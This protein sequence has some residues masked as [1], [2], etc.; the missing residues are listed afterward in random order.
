MHLGDVL[1]L[2]SP[3][4]SALYLQL[5][6]SLNILFGYWVLS[7]PAAGSV[8]LPNNSAS[9]SACWAEQ[10]LAVCICWGLSGWR[11]CMFFFKLRRSWRNA[12]PLLPKHLSPLYF[13][14]KL[15]WKRA[16][17]ENWQIIVQWPGGNDHC[18]SFI[19][20]ILRCLQKCGKLKW[21]LWWE[22]LCR[23]LWFCYIVYKGWQFLLL[24]IRSSVR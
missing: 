13:S 2:C 21:W 14:N 1:N 22:R 20:Q 23:K 4:I 12:Q 24:G 15:S 17:S 6:V 18:S 9:L 7:L 19:M 16:C 5:N 8:W 11:L 3:G 10:V